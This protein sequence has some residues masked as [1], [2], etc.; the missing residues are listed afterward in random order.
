M[1]CRRFPLPVFLLALT[2]AAA[3]VSAADCGWIVE[4]AGAPV[5]ETPSPNLELCRTGFLLSFGAKAHLALWAME[6]LT[7]GHLDGPVRRDG[8]NFRPDP[9]L[10]SG[11]QASL[12]DYRGSGF[13]RGHL[14]PAAD[15][16]WS[17]AAMA[18]SF[19]LTNIAPQV[20]VG[21][22]RGV[23]AALEA[24]IRAAARQGELVVV[25]GPVVFENAAT[26][27]RDRLP[28]P[29]AYYKA[30]FEPATGETKAWLVPNRALAGAG[31]GAFAIPLARLEALTGLDFFPLAEA[32]KKDEKAAAAP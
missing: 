13:D 12:A 4:G 20:G 21:F 23:W 19:Y 24:D 31:P 32:K 25:T 3:P 18:E 14:V 22:N 8:Q 5:A 17:E 11:E 9:S 29:A 10:A 1:A 16:T 15:L 6:R 26:F 28:V 30:V 2:L 7:P 27:G